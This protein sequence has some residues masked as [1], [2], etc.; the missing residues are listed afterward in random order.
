MKWA[1]VQSE[2][3]RQHTRQMHKSSGKERWNN[4]LPIPKR[5]TQKLYHDRNT[6]GLPILHSVHYARVQKQGTGKSSH[7]IVKRTFMEPR[8]YIVLTPIGQ[9]ICCK[10]QHVNCFPPKVI[11]NEMSIEVNSDL[12]LRTRHSD[13]NIRSSHQIIPKYNL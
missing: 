6:I 2:T 9:A 1:H 3:C 4:K 7:A 11:S 5:S 8:F 12:V 13:L 10:R